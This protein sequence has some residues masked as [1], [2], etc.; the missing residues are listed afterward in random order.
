MTDDIIAK[1]SPE[2]VAEE[3]A[4]AM[5]PRDHAS[6]LLGLRILTIRPGYARLAHDGAPGHGQRPPHLPRRP[7]LHA[8]RQRLRLRLQQLQQEHRRLGLPHRFP[9][10]GQGGRHP[11]GGSR[12][13]VAVG[14]HRRLRRHRAHAQRQDRR[15]LPRQVLPHQRRGHR[16]PAARRRSGADRRI[17]ERRDNHDRHETPPRRPRAD[18]DRQPRRDRGA[19]TGAPE[20]VAAPHLGQ[21][22]RLTAAKC[23]EKGVHPDDLKTLAD[24]GQVPLHDQGRPARQ[25]PVRPVRRAARQGAAPARLERARP[26]S[27]SSSATRRTTSTT[28]PT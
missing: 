16:R 5:W 8:R 2:V 28:G 24:L 10:A 1:D 26:A 19:A 14:P 6:Q 11:R 7:D 20:V 23:E 13:A 18:R 15:P 27:R 12:R 22:R 4:R 9:G 25:L 21:R 3:V 17:P